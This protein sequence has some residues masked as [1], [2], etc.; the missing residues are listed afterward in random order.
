MIERQC[1]VCGEWLLL[2][3]FKPLKSQRNLWCIQCT[4]TY[5]SIHTESDKKVAG[6][7]VKEA[8]ARWGFKFLK[9]EKDRE[10]VNE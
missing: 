7:W 8:Q 1:R 5:K 3:K 9:P 6:D 10:R 4:N 2:E